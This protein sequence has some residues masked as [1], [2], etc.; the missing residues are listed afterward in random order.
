[1]ESE[2]GISAT[3]NSFYCKLSIF[4]FHLII[5][6]CVVAFYIGLS[7]SRDISMRDFG[8]RIQ[9]DDGAK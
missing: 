5:R 9:Q 4:V 8:D 2:S 1:M 6:M 7:G 3:V